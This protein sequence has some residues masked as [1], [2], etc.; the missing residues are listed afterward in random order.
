MSESDNDKPVL[1]K[2]VEL[3]LAYPKKFAKKHLNWRSLRCLT[4]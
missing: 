2:A 3:V 4:N 1:L